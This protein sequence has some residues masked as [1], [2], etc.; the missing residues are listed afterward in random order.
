MHTPK[1]LQRQRAANARWRAAERRAQFEREDGIPDRERPTDGRAPLDLDLSTYGGPRLR[2]EP[3]PG[4]ISCR[5]TDI[6]T[7]AVRCAALKTLL[8]ELADVLPR[9]L[10]PRHC[11]NG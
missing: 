2:I 7:G 9:T 3:R 6:D 4:Y 1:N 5:A 8:H 11:G 10:S